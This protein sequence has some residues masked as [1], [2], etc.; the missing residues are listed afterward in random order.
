[1]KNYNL[2][3]RVLTLSQVIKD[4]E[5]EIAGKREHYPEQYDAERIYNYNLIDPLSGK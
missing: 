3:Y 1:M 4:F 2:S 5:I